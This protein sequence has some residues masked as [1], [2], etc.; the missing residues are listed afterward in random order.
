MLFPQLPTQIVIEHPNN[1]QLT[2][3]RVV[4]AAS[5]F[6]VTK[7][8]YDEKLLYGSIRQ[9]WPRL[10]GFD[11]CVIGGTPLEAARTMAWLGTNT[12]P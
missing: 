2:S 11:Q 8:R 10:L 5:P 6:I 4:G 7:W 1:P 9:R 3:V 12:R